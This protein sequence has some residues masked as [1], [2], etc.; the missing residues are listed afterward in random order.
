MILLDLMMP[1]MNGWDFRHEQLKDDELK[2]I[3]IIVLTAAGFSE[4][5]V[6]DQFGYVEFL[7]KHAGPDALLRFIRRRCEPPT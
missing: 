5:S 2:E 3:P 6:K 4:A 7:P 1:R